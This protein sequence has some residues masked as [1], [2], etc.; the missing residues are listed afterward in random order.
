MKTYIKCFLWFFILLC[1]ACLVLI[2]K[3]DCFFCLFG[4]LIFKKKSEGDFRRSIFIALFLILL[5]D[6]EGRVENISDGYFRYHIDS[7]LSKKNAIIPT[8]G[9]S[10]YAF[11]CIIELCSVRSDKV[12][13]ALYEYMVLKHSRNVSCNNNGVSN[14]YFGCCL[15]KVEHVIRIVEELLSHHN[16]A[17]KKEDLAVI[18]K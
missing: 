9:I 11:W 2:T 14:G 13:K 15:A 17:A 1:V 4:L 3:V 5:N 16:G 18:E 6:R 8:T 7:M 12:I 10:E